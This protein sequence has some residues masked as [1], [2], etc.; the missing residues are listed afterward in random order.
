MCVCVL[1]P[2]CS[3]SFCRCFSLPCLFDQDVREL[4]RIHWKVLVV[5]EAHRLKNCDSKLF[6]ELGSL[7]RDHSLLLTGTPLQNRTEEVGGV[8]MGKVLLFYIFFGVITRCIF[9][10][11]YFNS[12]IA[13]S[14]DGGGWWCSL[15]LC[16]VPTRKLGTRFDSDMMGNREQ[17][18]VQMAR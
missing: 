2:A 7:P 1:A 15:V 9:Y 4:S 5:D 18:S 17:P 6:Q 8:T 12:C 10:W 16:L 13:P 11:R 3:F 14:L